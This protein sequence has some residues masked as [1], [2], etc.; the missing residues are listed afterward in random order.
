MRLEEKKA[1]TAALA[2]KLD[3]AGVVYLTDFT[4]LGVEAMNSLR[5]KLRGK[6]AEYLVVKNTLA[7]RALEDLDLPDIVDHFTGPTGLVLTGTDPVPAAKVVKDF[8]AEHENRPLIKIGV[9]ERRE[10][11]AEAVYKMAD[12][13]SMDV[14]LGSIAGSLTAG[15]SGV[16][17]GIAAVIRDIAVM[18]E[19]VAK[20]EEAG[21]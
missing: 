15:V 13:P 11:S 19:E 21:V 2:S 8:A 18:I 1:A 20:K 9:V 14:L 10:I 3:K 5:R 16:V 12:L 6:D 4:G 7:R 17:G